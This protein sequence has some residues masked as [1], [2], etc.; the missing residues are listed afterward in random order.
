MD[1]S[2]IV[3]NQMQI[4]HL[5]SDPE[6]QR[7]GPKPCFSQLHPSLR[8]KTPNA[9]Q[10]PRLCLAVDRLCVLTPLPDS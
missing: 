3:M 6:S 9:S 10:W 7:L 8:T 4:G 1:I 5:S 2:V